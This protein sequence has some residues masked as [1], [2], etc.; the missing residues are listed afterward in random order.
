MPQPRQHTEGPAAVPQ[1]DAAPRQHMGEGA[2]WDSLGLSR[3]VAP[4]GGGPVLLL[5][6][7]ERVVTRGP[8]GG[9]LE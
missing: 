3:R 8:R 4:P 7:R 6:R 1:G 5:R 2:L 9:P